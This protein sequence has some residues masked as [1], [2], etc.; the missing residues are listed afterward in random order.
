M[1]W[2]DPAG[3]GG[4]L[5]QAT[6]VEPKAIGNAE[7]NGTGTRYPLVVWF[8]GAGTRG[9]LEEVDLELLKRIAPGPLVVAAPLHERFFGPWW[10]LNSGSCEWGYCDGTLERDRLRLLA[11]W[12]GVL[13]DVP[14]IDKNWLSLIGFSAG[15]YAVTELLAAAGPSATFAK[16][17]LR[18]RTVVLGGLHGHGQPGDAGL[19]APRKQKINEIKAKWQAYLKRVGGHCGAP[20]G[21]FAVHCRE[22]RVCPWNNAA[23]ILGALGTRQRLL[24]ATG[25]HL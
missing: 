15:A 25:G 16:N 7:T 18:P 9:G 5:F 6:I 13:L 21:I 19:D 17:T 11:T 4:V 12:L 10:V 20:G 23:L 1:L 3:V 24:I 2:K 14:E 22:D 8:S